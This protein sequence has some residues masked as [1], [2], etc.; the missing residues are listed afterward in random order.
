MK[1]KALTPPSAPCSLSPVFR[2]ISPCPISSPPLH[3]NYYF[4]HVGPPGRGAWASVSVLRGGLRRPP[5]PREAAGSFPEHAGSRRITAGLR[6][7]STPK[8]Y[9]GEP[10]VISPQL[11]RSS[12]S[13]PTPPPPFFLF[14]ASITDTNRLSAA[15]SLQAILQSV[16][17]TICTHQHSDTMHI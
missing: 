11:Q 8:I 3:Y 12:N 5:G 17:I 4:P 13:L 6:R 10:H 1:E 16:N 2:F 9:F 14:V 7:S 15:F